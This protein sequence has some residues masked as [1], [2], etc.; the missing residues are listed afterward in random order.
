MRHCGVLDEL[1]LTHTMRAPLSRL[2]ILRW[3]AEMESTGDIEAFG[4]EVFG[5]LFTVRR[6]AE[7]TRTGAGAMRMLGKLA[8]RDIPVAADSSSVEAEL[9]GSV[10]TLRES[11]KELVGEHGC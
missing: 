8:E 5:L 2:L 11:S 9:P 7:G 6:A 1:Q 4:D 3:L 10:A